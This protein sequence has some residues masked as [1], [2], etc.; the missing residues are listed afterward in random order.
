[1][2][3]TIATFDSPEPAERLANEMED[4]GIPTEIVDESKLQHYWFGSPELH[5]NFRLKIDK[6]TLGRAEE[7]LRK[8]DAAHEI[9]RD[10]VR[11][12]ECGSSRVEYPQFTRKF[13]LSALPSMFCR[14]GLVKAKYFCEDC[15]YTWLPRPG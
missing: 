3:L 4:S 10:A 6:Q 12:P 13:L 2:L 7:F 8:S 15:Q 1:M 9:L 14:L 11:C 5:A